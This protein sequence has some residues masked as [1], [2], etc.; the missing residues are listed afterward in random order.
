MSKVAY[1]YLKYAMKKCTVYLP[2]TKFRSNKS[3][4]LLF[5]LSLTGMIPKSPSKISFATLGKAHK[6]LRAK[7]SNEITQGK[8][9][10]MNT[11]QKGNLRNHIGACISRVAFHPNKSADVVY[12]NKTEKLSRN[13]C[14]GRLLCLG[15]FTLPLHGP[16]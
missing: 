9:L 15:Q 5:R 1:R 7:V 4:T 16:K 14:E 2:H 13:G 3:N 10:L 12:K 6:Y 8:I 11:P